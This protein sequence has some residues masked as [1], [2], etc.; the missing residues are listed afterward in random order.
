MHQSAGTGQRATNCCGGSKFAPMH[1]LLG[2]CRLMSQDERLP[3]LREGK[4]I[5]RDGKPVKREIARF[6]ATCGVAAML[7]KELQLLPEGDRRREQF[8]VY[9]QPVFGEPKIQPG[10][11]ALR[12]GGVYVFEDAKDWGS[13]VEGLMVH[14]DVDPNNPPDFGR[15]PAGD[16][17]VPDSP[18][19]PP[20]Q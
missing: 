14:Q 7:G 4:V 16:G 1:H 6:E 10:D 12:N 11:K 18:P 2:R 3:I 20:V 5:Y 17:S 9:Q 19:E 8:K 13:F 15:V